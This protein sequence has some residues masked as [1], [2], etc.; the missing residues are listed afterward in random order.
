VVVKRYYAEP[1]SVA[2]RARW[3]T[4]DRVFTSRVAYAEV[5]AALARKYRDGDLARPAFREDLVIGRPL[6]LEP[7]GTRVGAA[8]LVDVRRLVQRH[9]LRG[10]DAIHLAAAL[11]LR[12]GLDEALEFWVSDERLE[13]AARRERLMVVNPERP[14]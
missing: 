6:G 7:R 10:F 4:T 3:Q 1:G 9:G 12:R 11:W 8:T 13:T 2:V 5:H 14:A